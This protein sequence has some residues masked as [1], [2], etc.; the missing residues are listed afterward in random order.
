MVASMA[1]NHLAALEFEVPEWAGSGNAEFSAWENFSIGFGQPGNEPDIEGSQAGGVIVQGVPGGSVTGS[2]NI[3]NPVGASLFTLADTTDKSYQTVVLQAKSIGSLAADEVVLRYENEGGTVELGPDASR[4]IG[5]EAGGFGDTIIHLWSWDLTEKSIADID[6]IFNAQGPHLSLDAVRFD[7]LLAS[8]PLVDVN[9]DSTSLDRWNYSFNATPGK[10]P[11]A[12]VFRSLEEEVGVTRHGTFVVGFDTE[13]LIPADLAASQYA[14]ESI[15]IR[16]LTSSNFE[17]PYDPSYDPVSVFLP[18]GSDDR[19]EDSDLGHPV[20]LFGA[21]F[22]NEVDM[23]TWK[24]TDDYIPDGS[25]DRTVYP[26]ILNGEGELEDVTLAVDFSDPTDLIP[27]ALG[28]MEEGIPGD[29]IPEDSWMEF[30][31]DLE[32]MNTLAYLQQGL[33]AGRLMFTVTSLASGGQGDRTFPEFHTSDSLVGEAPTLMIQY[34]IGDPPS[35][36]IQILDF[37][38]VGDQWVLEVMAD[39]ANGLGVRWTE[40]FVN[41][42]EVLDPVFEPSENGNWQWTDSETISSSRFYQITKP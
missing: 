7:T 38:Q 40:D 41:W 32:Q 33:A 42:I 37:N 13:S 2:G 4:E 25:T 5:R 9:F 36:E 23:F 3:Y 15:K 39:S 19:T 31:I 29:F 16:L 10:R 24:E 6:L 35:S 22:R 17:A 26:A 1:M 20:E 18:E 8:G 11:K 27:F 28:K 14:I 12:S 21:G 30:D 34:R